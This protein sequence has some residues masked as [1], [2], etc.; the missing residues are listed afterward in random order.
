[1]R[2]KVLLVARAFACLEAGRLSGRSV[3]IPEHGAE[4][5]Y[6]RGRAGDG[7]GSGDAGGGGR[8]LS[9]ECCMNPILLKPTSDIGSQVIVNGEVAREHGGA[10]LF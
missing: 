6:Y 3:Q 5:L 1:M 4:F 2:E 9:P 7:P 10:G 8:G